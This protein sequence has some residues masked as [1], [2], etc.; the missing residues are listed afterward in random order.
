[1]KISK[2]IRLILVSLLFTVWGCKN[3]TTTSKAEDKKV[4]QSE[5]DQKKNATTDWEGTYFGVLPCASCPGINTLITLHPDGT[6][7]KT[8]EY[9]E[10]GD[11]PKTSKGDFSW[12]KADRISIEENSYLIE[13]NQLFYLDSTHKK[14]EGEL[15]NFY[16]FSK[17]ELQPSLDTN[18]GYTLQQYIGSDKKKYTIVFNTNPKVPTALVE[19]EGYRKILSQTQAWSK[20]AEY[21]GSNTKLIAKGDKAVL[22]IDGHRIELKSRD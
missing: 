10:S 1:M 15:A 7:E 4:H 11:T 16:V 19:T 13:N 14:Y 12:D 9:L 6:Y 20:G 2:N 8:V 18:E 5:T 3:N 22:I 17:T 21:A